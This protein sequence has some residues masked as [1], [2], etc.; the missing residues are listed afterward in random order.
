MDQR[1]QRQLKQEADESFQH[2]VKRMDDSPPTVPMTALVIVVPTAT[3]DRLNELQATGLWGE[4]LEQTAEW[5]LYYL[6]RDVKFE[7]TANARKRR[8]KA[9]AH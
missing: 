4:N 6:L 3:I 1:L 8:Q 7:R 9:G 5:M 2:Q